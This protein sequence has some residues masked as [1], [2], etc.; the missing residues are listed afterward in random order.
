MKIIE[1]I[2]NFWLDFFAA[3]FKRL[4]K[5]AKYETPLS[6]VLHVSFTQSVN[7]NTMMVII[8]HLFTSIKLNFF[9]LFTPI[10]IFSLL[11]SYYFYYKLNNQ[12]RKEIINRIPKYNVII[13]NFYDV[14]STILFLLTVYYFGNVFNK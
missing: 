10:V 14:F 7:F 3:Y 8:L 6:I 12:Q 9:L 11:N 4:I 13:Y 1:F 5:N 2:K